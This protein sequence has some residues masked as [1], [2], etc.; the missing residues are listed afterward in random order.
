MDPLADLGRVKPLAPG[1]TRASM[2][3]SA[4]IGSPCRPRAL[5]DR[6]PREERAEMVNRQSPSPAL[7]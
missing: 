7:S 3:V 1:Y 2:P 5:G 6:R 4:L